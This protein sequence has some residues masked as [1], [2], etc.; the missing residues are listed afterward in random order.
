MADKKE[1]RTRL[2]A[3]LKDPELK[4][5]DDFLFDVDLGMDSLDFLEYQSLVQDEFNLTVSDDFFD[6][7]ENV[8]QLIN[9]LEQELNSKEVRE[10]GEEV[11]EKG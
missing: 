7:V 4:I 8:G 3:L 1:I 6:D 11:Q 9:K 2:L 5:T 10:N